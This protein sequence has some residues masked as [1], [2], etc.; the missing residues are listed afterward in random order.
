MIMWKLSYILKFEKYWKK[1]IGW[2]LL[3]QVDETIQEPI[4]H[5]PDLKR[6]LEFFFFH[7]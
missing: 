5:K 2:G 6:T 1:Q 7:F 3:A 4:T